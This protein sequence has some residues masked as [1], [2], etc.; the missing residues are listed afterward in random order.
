MAFKPDINLLAAAMDRVI[1]PVDDL[2]GAGGMGL[3]E[4]V[5]EKS[6][7]DDRFWDA[8]STVLNALASSN[9]FLANSGDAQEDALRSVESLQPVAFNLW[10]DVVYTIYYMQP[11]VHRRLSWHG[12]PPQPDGNVMP[13]WDES[14]LDVTR[15][16]EPFWRQV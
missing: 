6:Q 12:R 13:P 10:L 16:R 14:V 5:V 7:A 9:E 4:V 1:P 2:A 3:A 11:E 15:Q 8:L